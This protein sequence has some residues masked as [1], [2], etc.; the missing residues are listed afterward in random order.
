MTY[1]SYM[2]YI[3]FFLWPPNTSVSLPLPPPNLFSLLHSFAHTPP[4][5]HQMSRTRGAAGLL[6]LHKG[7]W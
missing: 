4:T 6:P 5:S 1:I 7:T 3:S 2:T